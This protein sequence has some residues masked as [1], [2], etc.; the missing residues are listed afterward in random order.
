MA[1][2]AAARPSAAC[3]ALDRLEFYSV[4]DFFVSESAHHADIILP[5]RAPGL[6][7]KAGLG[8]RFA[9]TLG[10]GQRPRPQQ[11]PFDG[12]RGLRHGVERR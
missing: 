4:I 8:E 12:P 9:A 6:I 5:M 2:R 10:R 1:A 11:A 7:R 3:A